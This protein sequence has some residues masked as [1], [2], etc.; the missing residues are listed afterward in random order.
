MRILVVGGA[1]Y[2]GSHLVR[3]LLKRGDE[4]VVVDNLMT[5]RREF[6][7]QKIPFFQM[8]GGLAVG[9]EDVLRKYTIDAC[10]VCSL[11]NGG[12]RS[13]E[14]PFH[15][16]HNNFIAVFYLLQ[17]LVKHGVR[18]VILSSSL[19]IYGT[20]VSGPV[21]ENTATNPATPLGK[22]LSQCEDFLDDL[23][24]AE[25]LSCIVL[26]M[27]N[28]GGAAGDANI[29]PWPG[30]NNLVAALMDV[31]HGSRE[32]ISV[33]GD[34]A[35]DILHISDAVEAHMVSLRRLGNLAGTETFV[36]ASG[37]LL[38]L[39]QIIARAENITHR[40]IR[41][42]D[43]EI[44]F[45]PIPAM[46]TDVTLA[47]QELWRR[48]PLDIDRVLYGAWEWRKKFPKANAFVSGYDS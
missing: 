20:D 35:F 23:V 38:P 26:R 7:P 12:T 19:D 2:L 34:P 10:V 27:G 47:V 37:T 3:E 9:M 22:T 16:Y 30:S 42:Q 18:R 6:L 32:Y 31:A 36:L 39:S 44:P 4:A 45:D 28:I 8:D 43:G 13:L 40:K 15:Y 14:M 21:D 24:H 29:G 46:R 33:S 11:L 25:K 17:M 48:A 5:G 1:G 41:T